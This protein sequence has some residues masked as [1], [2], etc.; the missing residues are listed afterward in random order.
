LEAPAGFETGHAIALVANVSLPT[1]ST[2]K[3][4]KTRNEMRGSSEQFAPRTC[5]TP[6]SG[7]DP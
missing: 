5:G 4:G 1:K 3:V 6:R 7:C 2:A